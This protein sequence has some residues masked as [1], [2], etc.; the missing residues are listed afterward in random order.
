[1]FVFILFI[2]L[3]IIIIYLFDNC[4]PA[5]VVRKNPLYG[6]LSIQ[7]SINIDLKYLKYV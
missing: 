3:F 5:E 6:G 2:Y 7:L 4:I 1:M